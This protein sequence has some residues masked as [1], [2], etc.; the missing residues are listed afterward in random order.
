MIRKLIRELKE[1][2]MISWGLY[3]FQRDP[4]HN[5]VSI[6]DKKAIIEKAN[7][8]GRA[9]AIA[10][11]DKYGIKTC[12][13]YAKLL[14][15]KLSELEDENT[16]DYI[17]FA[18]FNSPNNISIYMKNV[19]KAEELIEKEKLKILMDGAKVDDVLIAHEMFH[20]IEENNKELY[21]KT[22]KIL[23]WK[24][25]PIKYHSGLVAPGEIAA[26]AFAKELLQLPYYPNLFDVLLLYPHN[27]EKSITLYKEVLAKI[28]VTVNVF[29][30]DFEA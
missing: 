9:E 15:I 18:R 30:R 22:L 25:G 20:F 6:M 28:K 24:L 4:I 26:M 16:K 1:V 17:L 2:G 21:T 7:E 23:L 12:H 27:K 5:K 13:E 19:K 11:R 29:P 3:S 14:G 10:L 8:C